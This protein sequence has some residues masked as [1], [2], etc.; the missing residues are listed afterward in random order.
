MN[1]NDQKKEITHSAPKTA[2]VKKTL[3]IATA[4]MVGSVFLSRVMGLIREQVIAIHGGTSFEIDAYVTAFLIPEIL[5]HFLAGG[6]LSVTFIPIYQKYMLAKDNRGASRCFSNLMTTGS[7]LFCIMIP[8]T[9]YYTPELLGF[10]GANISIPERREITIRLTRIILPAQILFYWG[11]FLSA[12]QMANQRFFYPALAPLIYNLGII[13]G[14]IFLGPKLGVEGFAWGVL[15]GALIGNFII[16]IP[17]TIRAGIKYKPRFDLT[18]PDLVKYVKLTV[19]L[20]LGLGLTFSNEVFFRFFGS[21]LGEGGT[22]SLNY[23]LR[24]MMMVVAVFGQAAGVAFFPFISRLAVEKEFEKMTSLLN[25]VLTQLILYIIPI[26]GIMIVLSPQI[27]SLLFQH[28]NFSAR[29]TAATAPILSVYLLGAFGFSAV[30][31]IARSFYAMQNTM[32]PMIVSTFTAVLSL[33]LYWFFSKVLGASGIAWAAVIS[34]TAQFLI[35]YSIWFRKYR[36]HKSTKALIR[37]FMKALAITLAGTVCC[38]A[39]KIMIGPMMAGSG[40]MI[41]NLLTITAAGLPSLL[42]IFYA[43]EIMGLQ[44]FKNSLKTLLRR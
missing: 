11:A 13:A 2:S 42:L 37:V 43:Y 3:T 31:I 27:I 18:D 40:A 39:I 9:I 22:A 5:N 15:G 12:V 29:S 23:A 41:V 30:M 28:G 20:V 35:L 10:M 7:L 44:N 26:T 4:I 32:L 16:Q 6:F 19:P 17:G 38:W 21:F 36:E 24:T 14:G 34:M 8:L 1:M 25:S 33:P